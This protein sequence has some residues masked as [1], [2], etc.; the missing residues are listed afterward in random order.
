MRAASL[1]FIVLL[2]CVPVI[3][4]YVRSGREPRRVAVPRE[5]V[6]NSNNYDLLRRFARFADQLL[7]EDR[8]V[9][10]SLTFLSDERRREAQELV[11]EF[12][13]QQK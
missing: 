13:R 2:V 3:V 9:S 5:H 6:D 7:T 8:M 10:G 12:Y 1:V 4:L 11:D